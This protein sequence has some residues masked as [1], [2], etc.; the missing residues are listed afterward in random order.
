MDQKNEGVVS[1]DAARQD[2]EDGKVLFEE[3]QTYFTE[4]ANKV[5]Y[6]GGK[7]QSGELQN[8]LENGDH[9]ELRDLYQK[10]ERMRSTTIRLMRAIGEVIE[11]QS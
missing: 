9:W 2:K 7:Q 5:F 10:C 1:L 6:L 11:K 4:A 3:L 8:L